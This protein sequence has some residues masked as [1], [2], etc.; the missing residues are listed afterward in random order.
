MRRTRVSGLGPREDAGSRTQ[1]SAASAV[2]ETA[3]QGKLHW[4]DLP[5]PESADPE[6]EPIAEGCGSFR[7]GREPGTT[8]PNNLEVEAEPPA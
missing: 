7:R 2:D 1:R 4:V 5:N 8:H 6:V 3:R